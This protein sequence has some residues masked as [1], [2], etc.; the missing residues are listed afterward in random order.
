MCYVILGPGRFENHAAFVRPCCVTMLKSV[1]T[2]LQMAQ[3]RSCL[4]TP[5]PKVLQPLSVTSCIFK[6]KTHVPARDA[7]R[8]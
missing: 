7:R 6:A 2:G 4:Q 3:K 5:G 1:D 8:G